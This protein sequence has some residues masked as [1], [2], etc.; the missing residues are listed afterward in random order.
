MAYRIF[1]HIADSDFTFFYH[2]KQPKI[3]SLLAIKSEDYLL[4]KNWDT[5]LIM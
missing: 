3:I 5:Q 4:T 1:D 2:D